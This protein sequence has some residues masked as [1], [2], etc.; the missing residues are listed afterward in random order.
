MNSIRCPRCRGSLDGIE[1]RKVRIDRCG[2]CSGVWFD[3]GELKQL[4]EAD[5]EPLG[6]DKS[7]AELRRSI[8]GLPKASGLGGRKYIKCPICT[9]LLL[10]RRFSPNTS[11]VF[12]HCVKHGVWLDGDELT[13][14]IRKLSGTNPKEI[15]VRGLRAKLHHDMKLAP[16]RK[17]PV[18][19]PSK[20]LVETEQATET[21]VTSAPLT[22]PVPLPT[23]QNNPKGRELTVTS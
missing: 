6:S 23:A 8:R 15:T 14:L 3:Q 22:V 4:L 18:H 11:L 17:D 21:P 16:S 12:D 13:P 1:I 5:K 7:I 9:D 2:E 20:S 10:R 19:V